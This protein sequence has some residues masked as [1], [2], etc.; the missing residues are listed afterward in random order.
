MPPRILVVDDEPSVADLIEAV[1]AGEGY[2]VAI[3]RDGAQGLMLARDWNPDLILMDI[4]LPAVDGSTAI[5]RLKAD[6]E[7]AEIPIVAMSAGRT[8]RSQSEALAN[9]DAALAK[10]FDIDALL[11]QVAFHLSRRPPEEQV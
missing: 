6:P 11:A 1:L 8:I 7:T 4:M 9:A 5:R 2:T 10:P 3:A